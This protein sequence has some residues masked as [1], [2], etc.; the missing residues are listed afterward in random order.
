MAKKSRAIYLGKVTIGNITFTH[1]LSKNPTVRI[2][3]DANIPKIPFQ[4]K[5]ISLEKAIGKNIL[6]R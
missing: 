1:I 3:V 6:Y 4:K 2:E 5:I